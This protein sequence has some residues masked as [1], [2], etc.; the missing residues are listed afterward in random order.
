MSLDG[1]RFRGAPVTATVTAV[2][3]LAST[4]VRAIIGARWQSVEAWAIETSTSTTVDVGARACAM[5]ARVFGFC[6]ST[7]EFVVGTSLLSSVGTRVERASGTRRFAG[8]LAALAVVSV[9]VKWAL[10]VGMDKDACGPYALVFG[11][12]RVY[13]TETPTAVSARDE[14]REFV[15]TDKMVKYFGACVLAVSNGGRSMRAAVVGTFA[16][17]VV[18]D[19]VGTT[20][21]ALAL[22]APGWWPRRRS[23]PIVRMRARAPRASGND[24]GEGLVPPSESNVRVLTSMGFD[25]TAARRALQRANDDVQRASD[26]L[27]SG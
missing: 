20:H 3:V 11:L 23:R 7:G 21:E 2:T 25:E 26:F 17:Y 16:G 24:S 8:V 1:G 14:A 13:A 18:T 27:L 15:V 12:M 5:A 10:G 4:L 9:V 22:T 6:A 19:G